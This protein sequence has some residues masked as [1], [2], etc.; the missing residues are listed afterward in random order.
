M[1]GSLSTDVARRLWVTA[2]CLETSHDAVYR[3]VTDAEKAAC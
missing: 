2:S 1:L 3:A